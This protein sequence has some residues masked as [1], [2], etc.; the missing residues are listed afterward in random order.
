MSATHF[1]GPLLGA[2]G[3]TKNL[4]IF[5][6]PLVVVYF[7][8]FV[9]PSSY[10]AGD[11]D[12]VAVGSGSIGHEEE[13]NGLLRITTGSSANDLEALFLKDLWL[14]TSDQIWFEARFKTSSIVNITA[15]LGLS[16]GSQNN[17]VSFEMAAST[18]D[19]IART[20]NAT[21]STREKIADIDTSSEWTT[22]SLVATDTAVDYYVNRKY[23]K[24]ITTN[25][26][27]TSMRTSL[28]IQTLSANARS[29]D[30]D[31]VMTVCGRRT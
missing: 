22:V 5:L 8:D 12:I 11:W 14:L 16:D 1:V 23:A 31:Y 18:D 7:N 21:V 13:P 26:P 27:T 4:P 17:Q 24:T 25:I 9:V 29:L 19:L 2:R 3:F 30:V 28:L 10:Q 20:T 15:L 6:D